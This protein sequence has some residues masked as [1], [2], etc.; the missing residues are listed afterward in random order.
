M[1][2]LMVMGLCLLIYALAEHHLRQQLLQQDQTIPDQKGKPTQRPTL[3][4]VFQMFEGI[5]VLT[6]MVGGSPKTHGHQCEMRFMC[7]LRPCSAH[8]M[9]KFYVFA[10]EYPL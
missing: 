4:R 5:H 2:L 10:E 3:R 1:A 8:A 9:L 7:R 6:I